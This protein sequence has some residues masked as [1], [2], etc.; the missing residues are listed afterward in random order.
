MLVAIDTHAIGSNLAGNERYI[1]NLADHLL[2]QDRKN[3]YCFFFSEEKARRQWENRAPNLRTCLVSRNQFRRLGIDFFLQL[4]RLRPQVF[5]Y[6]YTGPLLRSCPE[7]VTVHDVSFERHPEFFSPVDYLRLRLTVRRAVRSARRILTVSEFS[8]SEIVRLLKVPEEN[9]KVIYNGVGSEFH[10]NADQNAIQECLNGYGIRKPY[11]LAVGTI[12]RRKNQVALVRAFARWA[13]RKQARPYRVV[14]VGKAEGVMN[15]LRAEI[16]RLGLDSSRI[17]LLGSV[18]GEHLPCLYRGAEALVNTSL[19]E[20]FGL[21]VVEA[22]ACGLPVI[23]S[24]TSCFPEIAGN[25]AR[26]VDPEKPE[27]IADAIEEVLGSEALRTQLVER[28]LRRA[29][30]FR[31]DAAARETLKIYSESA[32]GAKC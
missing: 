14:I 16:G 25:A 31:W 7:V 19:Y 22:M 32:N 4:R 21:P 3:E 5:H 27:A 18:A 10:P 11:L 29:Q 23:A 15:A 20:G 30:C 17:A 6:Q 1:R 2:A 12:C 13:S 24:G 28:G 9:V 26:Y 8:K